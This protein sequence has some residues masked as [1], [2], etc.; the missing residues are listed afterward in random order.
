[1]AFSRSNFSICRVRR[2]FVSNSDRSRLFYQACTQNLLF[3]LLAVTNGHLSCMQELSLK[4]LCCG[5]TGIFLQSKCWHRRNNPSSPGVQKKIITTED[6]A[7]EFHPGHWQ[8]AWLSWIWLMVQNWP[9][10]TTTDTAGL[11]KERSVK[12]KNVFHISSKVVIQNKQKNKT[13]KT[14]QPKFICK[15]SWKWR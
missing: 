7:F 1:M 13:R 10:Y 6:S 15:R 14:D 8:K 4:S 2:V 5:F 11:M 3:K 12:C 9:C